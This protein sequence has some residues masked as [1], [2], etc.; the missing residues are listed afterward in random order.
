MNLLFLWTDEQRPDTIAAYRQSGASSGR[1]PARSAESP[2]SRA[3]AS[4]TPTGTPI[5][6]PNLD[7][8]AATGVLFEQA[9]CAQPVCTPS[10]GTVL[11]GVYPHTH[12]ST[13]NNIPLPE[14]IPTVAELLAP[15][16]YACG[17]AGKWHLGHELTPQRG[18]DWWA[19]M[20]DGYVH[21]HQKDGFSTYHHW[22]IAK[23][24][25][26]P[27]TAG[28]GSLVFSRRTAAALPEAAG[29]PAF[30]AD[31]AC[32]FLDE[33]ASFAR[34]GQPFALYVNFLE[35]HMPFTGPWDQM[36]APED[37]TLAETWYTAPDEGMPLR[38]Q[39]RRAHY[40]E[41][42][43]HIGSDDELSWKSLK[44][45]YWGLASLVDK[46]CGVILDHLDDLGLAEDTV[47]V[48]STDHGDMMGEHRLV[49]KGVQYEG[50]SRVP[51]IVRIP[52][53]SSR[54]VSTPIGQ[55]DILPTLLDAL[56]VPAPD[57]LQ[58]GSLLPVMKDGDAAADAIADQVVFEWSGARN[59]LA[60]DGHRFEGG[61]EAARAIAAQQRTI[62][63]DRWKLTVD[64][65][66][67]HELY[68]LTSDPDETR[69]LLFAG[70]LATSAAAT[71][72][73][74]WQRLRAWQFRTADSLIL[75]EPTS[76]GA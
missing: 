67:Q 25:A 41:T 12:G 76:W 70:R 11:T 66:G 44:A 46:Y 1:S 15:H 35:P 7:R 17:Y 45:R 75:P 42:R 72:P 58:G 16:G 61:E 65:Y 9:Y 27:D 37:M 22:L 3:R 52:G 50:A 69:N 36:Y 73:D 30:L 74:L 57:H 56:G 49:A 2:R 40:A 5:Q 24:Y 14:H 63:H 55:V 29:K 4:S 34:T 64:E 51:L 59:G 23:G 62:R 43:Q 20:E 19:S 71:L 53:F 28:D 8:L 18:F 6:S 60:A 39:V 68:D 33:H 31:Q 32:R 26:P 21:D 48:Y 54:R 47:I 10:R 38:H 13:H